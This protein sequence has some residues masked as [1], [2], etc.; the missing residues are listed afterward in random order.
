M[1]EIDI[2]NIIQ[3]N[4]ESKLS[5]YSTLLIEKNKE[6][7]KEIKFLVILISI[8][9][10]IY[11]FIDFQIIDSINILF[12]SLKNIIILKD[13]FSLILSFLIFRQVILVYKKRIH[14]DF[15]SRFYLKYFDVKND[16]DENPIFND[17]CLSIFPT[18]IYEDIFIIEK[19][20]K[21]T[22]KIIILFMVIPLLFI[23][24]TPF[25]LEIIWTLELLLKFNKSN[26][27]VKLST[28]ISVLLIPLNIYYYLKV[29]KLIKKMN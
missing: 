14:K 26:F 25:V 5:L 3:N 21:K 22:P 24:L 8:I 11:Y 19:N 28:I 2:D 12:I 1:K 7:D 16:T 4:N 29:I 17:F 20:Y 10:G 27:L 13:F 9:I 15:V 18:S 23:S 6:I